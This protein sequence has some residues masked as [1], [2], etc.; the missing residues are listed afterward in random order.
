MA[1]AATDQERMMKAI[2]K[3]DE[4]KRK[5]MIPKFVLVFL[6]HRIIFKLIDVNCSLH[7]RVFQGIEST[8]K[9]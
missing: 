3:L 6:S 5:K 4:K 9:Q 8:G 2:A 1:S 7:P